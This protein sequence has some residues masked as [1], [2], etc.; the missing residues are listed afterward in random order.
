VNGVLVRAWLAIYT[1]SI[2]WAACHISNHL[3]NHAAAVKDQQLQAHPAVNLAL[4]QLCAPHAESG[5]Q[6]QE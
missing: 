6:E 2:W 1:T 4:P 5:V 3:A